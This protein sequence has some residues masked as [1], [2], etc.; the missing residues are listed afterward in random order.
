MN[1]VF[2]D[3]L[4]ILCYKINMLLGYKFRIYPTK[5]QRTLL[6]KHFGACRF[7][8]N[9][10]LGKYL[11]SKN[12]PSKIQLQYEL[13]LLK[14]E[15][16]WLKEINSQ[17][18]QV[19]VQRLKEAYKRAFTKD[20]VK[21]RK[22]AI[23]KARTVKQKSNAERFGFPN[24]KSKKYSLQSFHVPQYV[25]IINDKLYIPKFKTGI[26]V[27]FHRNIPEKG[28]IKNATITR[29]NNKYYVSFTIEIKE[30]S[31]KII[32]FPKTVGIDVGLEH[33]ITLS[34]PLFFE[35]KYQQKINFPKYYRKTERKLKRAQRILSRKDNDSSNRYKQ[36]LKVQKLHEKVANQRRDF[37]HKLST[38]ITKQFD[39]VCVENLNIDGMKRNNR[40]AKSISDAGWGMFINMLEYKLAKKNGRLIK[41]DRFYPSSKTCNVCGYKIED[42]PLYK[43]KWQCPK[44]QTTHNRDINASINIER[45]GLEQSEFTPVEMAMAG[46]H[47]MS[48]TSQPSQKQEAPAINL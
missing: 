8:W 20:I 7:V 26:K 33:F 25:K 39:L 28:I 37:L 13:K 40:L 44:C 15:K 47:S 24:F 41:I 27:K 16:T 35:N 14:N 22:K 18:L 5:E 32:K 21:K 36:I 38:A 6:N 1:W 3:F 31:S 12:F 34:R 11:N 48:V 2:I 46:L 30:Q 10:F 23:K 29:K 4:M 9:Y 45:V 17:S 42:L 43:R 19:V